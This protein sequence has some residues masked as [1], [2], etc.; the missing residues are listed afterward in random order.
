LI[1][2]EIIPAIDIK[3]G[4]CV[5]LTQGKAGTEKV[6]YQKPL[7]AAIYWE[8]EMGTKRIHFVDLDAA[9]GTGDNLPMIKKIINQCSMKVQIGG[10]I[11]S[12]VKAKE[13]VNIGVDRIII[14]T[15]AVKEPDFIKTLSEELGSEHIMVSLDHV[16]GKVAI[17]G[18]TELTE[19]DAFEMGRRFQDLGAGYILF[20]A[21]EA[22]GSMKGPDIQ[23]TKKMVET[24]DIPVFAA[25]GTRNVEDILELRNKAKAFGVIIGKAF[26]EHKIDFREVKDL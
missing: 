3:D 5:R 2:L 8:K 14:G 6:Y 1:K 15:K 18:W 7:D 23:N 10:G 22:D 13:L 12:L 4:K 11:R 21:V 25:G 20:S 24:V 17:K 26:Y 19:N 9:M 16:K